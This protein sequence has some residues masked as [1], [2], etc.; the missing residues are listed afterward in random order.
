MLLVVFLAGQWPMSTWLASSWDFAREISVSCRGLGM[1]LR[2]CCTWSQAALATN[3]TYSTVLARVTYALDQKYAVSICF[4]IFY[5]PNWYCCFN[6][7]GF[8]ASCLQS[9]FVL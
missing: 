4:L 8:D 6:T 1:I 3:P 9:C 5:I 7:F 2:T